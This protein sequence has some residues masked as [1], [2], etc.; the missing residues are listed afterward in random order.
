MATHQQIEV[1]LQTLQMRQRELKRMS[2][3]RK[4]HREK[5]RNSQNSLVSGKAEYLEMKAQ[6]QSLKQSVRALLGEP[7]EDDD[8]DV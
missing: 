4:E 1:A 7:L 8:A 2:E 3:D 5:I 6:V